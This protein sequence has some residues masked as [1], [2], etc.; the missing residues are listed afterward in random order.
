MS[1]WNM[2]CESDTLVAAPLKR[3]CMRSIDRAAMTWRKEPFL[4]GK[5]FFSI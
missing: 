3:I 2:G 5:D 4:P 1:G